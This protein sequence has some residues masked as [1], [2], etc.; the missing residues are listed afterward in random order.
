[1]DVVHDFS[2]TYVTGLEDVDIGTVN[3]I[4]AGLLEH[5][6]EAL[7]GDGFDDK[8]RAFVPSAE[9]RYQGQEH[10]VNL[11]MPGHELKTGDVTKIVDNFNAAHQTQYG[12]SMDDPVEIVTLRMRAV[13]LLPRPEIPKIGKGTGSA[14]NARKGSRS[15]YL[16]EPGKRVDYPVYERSLLLSSDRI[17]GPAIIEEPSSTTVIHAG[18]VLTV[19]EYGELVIE[20]S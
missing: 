5:G 11:P 7:A 3:E 8:Q 1:V 19:G 14:D 2:Q 4:Y 15:V 20:V 13:G 9:L 6:Q 18:D 16:Y 12:H 10:T 17:E